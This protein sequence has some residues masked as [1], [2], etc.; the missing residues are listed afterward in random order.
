MTN[1][2]QTELQIA[3]LEEFRTD[4]LRYEKQV[5]KMTGY[6]SEQREAHAEAVRAIA[7]LVLEEINNLIHE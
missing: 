7:A 5:P 2:A 4:L 3:K 6:S 1:R